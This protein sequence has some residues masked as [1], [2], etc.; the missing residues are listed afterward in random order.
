MRA[1]G[2]D[3]QILINWYLYKY[4]RWFAWLWWVGHT[5]H[6]HHRAEAKY[7]LGSLIRANDLLSQQTQGMDSGQPCALS[8][9]W[10]DDVAT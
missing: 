8:V 6:F 5:S 10:L 4:V 1:G 9:V 7:E 2:H 3:H